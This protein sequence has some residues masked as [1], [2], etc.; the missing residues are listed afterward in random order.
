MKR[1]IT[2]TVAVI[3][4]EMSSTGFLEIAFCGDDCP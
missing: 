1:K 3:K 2:C 4:E